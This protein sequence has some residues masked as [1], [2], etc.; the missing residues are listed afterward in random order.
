MN[1]DYAFLVVFPV[2]FFGNN[3]NNRELRFSTN[4][5]MLYPTQPSMC[6]FGWVLLVC[7]LCSVG[8]LGGRG[9]AHLNFRQLSTM[10]TSA[11]H[12]F[13]STHRNT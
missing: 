7:L 1:H 10:I 8:F 2:L 11:H 13:C 4:V 6:Y 3:L 5:M 12:N 9:A